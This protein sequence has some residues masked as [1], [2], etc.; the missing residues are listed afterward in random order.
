MTTLRIKLLAAVLLTL[1][2]T[3][4]ASAAT[5]ADE[6]GYIDLEWIEIPDGADEV[7]DIDL[8]HILLGIAADA[9]NSGDE[10]LA[11]ALSMVRSIRVKGFSVDK[12][13]RDD[14]DGY[15][16]RIERTLKNEDW[17]RLIYVRDDEESVTVSTKYVGDKLVGLTI[18]TFEPGDSVAFINVA[19][20]LDLAT[21]FKLAGGFDSDSIEDMLDELEDVEGIEIHRH[22]EDD[23]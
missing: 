8:S 1:F 19:G 21:L 4:I 11:Q 23:D 14:V 16:D 3:G 9:E 6:P 15:I 5:G 22:E 12:Y 13:N 10:E 17:K 18:V 20:D 2:V 7:Q